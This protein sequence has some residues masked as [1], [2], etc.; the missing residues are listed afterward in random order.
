M[1]KNGV[2]RSDDRIGACSRSNQK[3]QQKY[4]LSLITGSLFLNLLGC[5]SLNSRTAS[6]PPGIYRGLR[7][8]VTCIAASGKMDWTR[9]ECIFPI[10]A[11][12]DMPLSFGVD[13]ILLP[14]DYLKT[15]KKETK[16]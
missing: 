5:A 9:G 15:K 16:I 2:Y 6:S 3:M 11:V 8:D 1:G 14:Y 10:E 13:T 12:L 4:Y 7:E